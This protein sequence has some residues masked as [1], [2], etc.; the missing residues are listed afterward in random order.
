MSANG[1]DQGAGKWTDETLSMSQRHELL[2][3]EL[4]RLAPKPRA[5][6]ASDAQAG[7]DAP[8]TGS[9]GGDEHPS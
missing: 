6:R 9:A 4:A 8:S 3:Q 1:D 7:G 2:V 5:A